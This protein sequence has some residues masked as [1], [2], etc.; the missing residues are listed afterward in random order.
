MGIASTII[1][2]G[3]E[4]KPGDKVSF[5]TEG[6]RVTGEVVDIPSVNALD[7]RYRLPRGRVDL[8]AWV[9]AGTATAV[10]T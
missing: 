6:L 9:H 10:G 1:N 4:V 3:V 5:I 7:V 8:Y 2:G